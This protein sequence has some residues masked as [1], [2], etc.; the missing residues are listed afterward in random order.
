MI[1]IK[2][3]DRAVLDALTRLQGRMS[4]MTT[5]MNDIGEHLVETSKRR[6]DTSTAP[7]GT[8]WAKNSETTLLRHLGKGKGVFSTSAKNKGE[9]TKKAAGLAASKKPL[10]GKTGSLMVT[11]KHNAGSD[12]VEIGSP[13]EYA[14]MQQFGGQKS[15]FPHLWGDIPARPFL[16]VSDQDRKS[17]LD[18]ISGYLNDS[19][20]P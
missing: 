12:F 4:N 8:P 17:I 6:F 16:G 9:L 7:D 18:I 11:I 14:A 15:K 10:I 3:D 13:E 1:T 20:S 19:I 5:V 2:I